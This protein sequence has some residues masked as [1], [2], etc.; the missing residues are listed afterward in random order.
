VSPRGELEADQGL[1]TGLYF[2]VFS[3]TALESLPRPSALRLLSLQAS[4]RRRPP[5]SSTER[6]SIWDNR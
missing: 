4:S 6:E 1:W 5:T 2:L 3:L